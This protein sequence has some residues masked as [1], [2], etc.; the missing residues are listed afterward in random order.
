[1][2]WFFLRQVSCDRLVLDVDR[3]G[4][5][6]DHCGR[7]TR[8][9]AGWPWSTCRGAPARWS[10]R[11]VPILPRSPSRG[12]PRPSGPVRR[13]RFPL[14]FGCL[15]PASPTRVGRP[16]HSLAHRVAGSPSAWLDSAN[17]R[18]V[19]Q[20]G[21]SSVRVAYSAPPGS[22]GLGS[23]AVVLLP[24][25]F[26][27]PQRLRGLRSTRVFGEQ[28]HAERRIPA[29]GAPVDL[30]PLVRLAGP[31]RRVRGIRARTQDGLITHRFIP[32]CAGKPRSPVTG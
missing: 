17:L 15:C 10:D 31:S 5:A 25:P 6:G 24:S 14:W 8:R 12:P 9:P 32:A 16:A 22:A 3:R 1:M 18:A 11:G 28:R 27:F 30:D 13:C 26:R 23:S 4:V 21:F 20:P 2:A 7:A 29:T 19:R